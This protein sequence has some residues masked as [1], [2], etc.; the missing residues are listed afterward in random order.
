[1]YQTLLTD[2]SSD[3]LIVTINRPDKLNALN[4]QVFTDLDKVID[5]IRDNPAIR[6]AIVTGAGS[7]AFV[8]G[9]DIAE[10]STLNKQEA[11]VLARRGQD[12]FFK[13][14]NCSKPIISAV[15]G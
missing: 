7:K 12:I 10:I 3:I 15:N 8:A 4:Q 13:I 14:E 5:E 11:L 9:A 2:L 6:S 1:M